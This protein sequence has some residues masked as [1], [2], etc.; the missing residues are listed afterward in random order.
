MTNDSEGVAC[1][2]AGLTTIFTCSQ[3]VD[4]FL[5]K[6]A[7]IDLPV[8][9][10]LDNNCKHCKTTVAASNGMGHGKAAPG[11]ATGKLATASQGFSSICKFEENQLN[12]QK[13]GRC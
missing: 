6:G 5:L 12:Q 3:S 8:A 11:K 4:E 13:H 2:Q 7:V 10:N 9:N 1:H